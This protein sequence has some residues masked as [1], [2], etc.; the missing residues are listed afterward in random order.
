VLAEDD[1]RRLRAMFARPNPEAVPRSA[2]EHFA[3]SIADRGASRRPQLLPRQPCRE[4]RAWERLANIGDNDADRPAL[5]DQDPAWAAR[6]GGNRRPCR[7]E[8][9]LIVLDGA[10]HWLQSKRPD[11][12]SSAPR[13]RA[14]L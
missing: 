13:R 8:Y 3:P 1:Y 9:K 10:G 14:N 11:E 6:S 7:G 2:I 5:G 4:W 12:V